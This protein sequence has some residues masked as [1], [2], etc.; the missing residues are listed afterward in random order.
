MLPFSEEE[1]F[2]KT[3]RQGRDLRL[4]VM[5]DTESELA[6]FSSQIRCTVVKLDCLHLLWKVKP[7]HQTNH[8]PHNLHS[9]LL[10]R[11]VGAM[12]PETLWEFPSNV[13][14][15]LRSTPDPHKKREPMSNTLW[16]ARN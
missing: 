12:V 16:T 10:A 3:S 15:N 1:V 9:A 7:G 4:L 5:E 14:F 2:L 6:I 11:C 8:N 13:W